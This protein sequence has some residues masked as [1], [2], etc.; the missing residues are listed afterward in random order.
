LCSKK[1]T[2][3]GSSIA[4]MIRPFASSGVDGQTH[5]RPGM[6]ANHDRHGC[7]GAPALL[8][9]DR[10]EVVPRAGDEVGELHLGHRAKP[11]DRRAG[12]AAHDRCLGERHVEHAPRAELLLKAL[13]DLE[14]AAVDA[15][16]LAEHEHAL[17]APHL[18]AEAV[19][20]RLEVSLL[21]HYLW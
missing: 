8:G 10:H 6:C 1:R 4:A 7:A 15:D 20:D 9:R 17:V 19:G 13:G 14:R 12:G 18:R 16:V 3:F 2:G 5:L 21:R 11:H